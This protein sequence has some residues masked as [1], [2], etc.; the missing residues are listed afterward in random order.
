MSEAD[1]DSSVFINDDDDND[2]EDED[3]DEEEREYE[4]ENGH[5]YEYDSEE[6]FYSDFCCHN[7]VLLPFVVQLFTIILDQQGGET[8]SFS[9]ESCQTVKRLLQ[10][11]PEAARVYSNLHGGYALHLA[12][13]KQAPLEIIVA[14][15]NPF[16]EALQIC[17][18]LDGICDNFDDH[19]MCPLQHALCNAKASFDVIRFL[20][21]QWPGALQLPSEGGGAHFALHVACE[22]NVSLQ[23]IQYLIKQWPGVLQRQADFGLPLH[24]ACRA[25]ADPAT[26][27]FLIQ[28]WPDA[29]KLPKKMGALP[30]HEACLFRGE[31]AE[32]S[33]WSAYHMALSLAAASSH[34]SL[35]LLSNNADS[36]PPLPSSPPPVVLLQSL[37][38]AWPAAVRVRDEEGFLPLHNLCCGAPALL[39]E[40]QLLV[41]AW[42][43]ALQVPTIGSMLPL[44]L[45]CQ[46]CFPVDVI[47]YLIDSYPLAAKVPNLRCELPLHIACTARLNVA[48]IQSLIQVW[49]DSVLVP[50]DYIEPRRYS[51]CGFHISDYLAGSDE[52]G[53]VMEDEDDGEAVLA[54]D[55]VCNNSK[56]QQPL[57]MEFALLLTKGTPPLYFACSQPCKSWFPYREQT[58][59][60]LAALS[61]PE[62]WRRFHQGM[63]PL[64][65]ACR[66]RAE[67]D[68][69]LWLGEKYPDSL[70]TCTTDTMDSPLHCYLSSPATTTTTTATIVPNT[71]TSIMPRDDDCRASHFYSRAI[72]YL[73]EQNPAAL[74]SANRSGWLPIHLAAMRNVPIDILFYLLRHCPESLL[75]GHVV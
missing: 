67:K 4:Y 74:Y 37:V 3:E 26:I 71:T 69:L 56:S 23:I 12:C 61:A 15:A 18:K 75:Q 66:S 13:R 17:Q 70:R 58:L 63:L 49:P 8:C 35:L 21:S 19:E 64:H 10:D 25:G 45:A 72:Q 68:I 59:E 50:W 53:V 43:D 2:D 9:P 73:V 38:R 31:H 30:L 47:Q 22:A 60:K 39:V 14:L 48:V 7:I 34:P 29:L 28:A 33:T 54:L 57:T 65:C 55:L 16:P 52:L 36:P 5:G 1:A 40:V 27:D 20:V 32:V 51:G 24:Y 46:H 11:H 62:D 42:P 41:E 6:D 44:H